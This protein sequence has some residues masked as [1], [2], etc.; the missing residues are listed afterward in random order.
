MAKKETSSTSRREASVSPGPS[1]RA[2]DT[3]PPTPE[4]G[5]RLIDAFFKIKHPAL[6]EA[7]IR[8]VEELSTLE[9]NDL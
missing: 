6:R 7:V 1:A 5:R 2:G 8:I 3:S 4:D 9:E